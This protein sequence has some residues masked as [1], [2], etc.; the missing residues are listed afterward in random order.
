MILNIYSIYD[1]AAN[2]YMPPFFM[3][4]HGLATR[5]FSDNANNKE[6]QIGQHPE[7]FALFH[8]GTFDDENGKIESFETPKSLGRGNEFNNDSAAISVLEEL[9]KE[10]KAVVKQARANIYTENL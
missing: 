5:A 6:S 3:H 7:Q 1:D 10:L 2:A 9:V 4:N 8:I